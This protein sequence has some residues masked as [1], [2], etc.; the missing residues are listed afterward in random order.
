MPKCERPHVPPECHFCHE[1]IRCVSF[2][3]KKAASTLDSGHSL[4][5]QGVP[6]ETFAVTDTQADLGSDCGLYCHNIKVSWQAL[7]E[8]LRRNFDAVLW[9]E[10]KRVSSTLASNNAAR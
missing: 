7:G 6:S 8:R 9:V 3:D 4:A 5:E 10:T 1:E 2:S